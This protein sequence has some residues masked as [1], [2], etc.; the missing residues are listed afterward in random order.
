MLP[1]RNG[2]DRECLRGL[3][4]VLQGCSGAA[5]KG[6]KIMRHLKTR[7]SFPPPPAPC[8]ALLFLTE[9]EAAGRWFTGWGTQSSWP[10]S[11]PHMSCPITSHCSH[12]SSWSFSFAMFIFNVY[13][14]II[15]YH[16]VTGF[17]YVLFKELCISACDF[18]FLAVR[19]LS[20]RGWSCW[21][22]NGSSWGKGV[23]YI[24]L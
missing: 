3:P 17:H 1:M 14:N 2:T 21:Y 6:K 18:Y 9:P 5:G 20:I 24:T 19:F 16:I 7:Q 8:P 15:I 11:S 22:I 10:S 4:H 13:L 12:R 23:I